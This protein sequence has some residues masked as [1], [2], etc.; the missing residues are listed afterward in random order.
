MRMPAFF[1][2]NAASWLF[3]L[4]LFAPPNSATAQETFTYVTNNGTITIT[5]YNR[6]EP[7]VTIPSTINGLPVRAIGNYAFY[8]SVSLENVTIANSVSRIGGYAFLSCPGLTNVTLGNGV[9]RIEYEAFAGCT[10]LPNIRIP[11]SVTEIGDSAFYYC[12]SL[13]AIHV[14]AGNSSYSSLDGVLFDKTQQIL[15]Q[16]PGGKTGNYVMPNSVTDFLGTAFNYSTNLSRVTISAQVTRIPFGAF[17]GC[18]GLTGVAIPDRVISIGGVAFRDCTRLT[19]VMIPDHVTHIGEAAFQACVALTNVT[20]GSSITNIGS[21]AFGDCYGL[22]KI[23]V[24]D[25]VKSIGPWAFYYCSGLTNLS[26]GR[27]LSA[28]REWA[29]AYCGGL[30]SVVM[31]E[32]LQS[33]GTNAFD[34]CAVLKGL[35]FQGNAPASEGEAFSGAYDAMMYYLPGTTGWGATFAGRPT[36]WWKLLYPVILDF[37]PG[38]GF[39][40]NRFGFI[41]SWATNAS[42]VVEACTNLANPSW[43]RLATNSLSTAG[44]S[45]FSDPKWTNAA[46]RFYR[47]RS[48]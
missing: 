7:E 4:L 16:Y 43:T 37:P 23:G 1:V 3:P 19:E 42:V 12:G 26:L 2:T 5:S 9:S 22:T 31:P 17:D 28:I 29:F 14:D 47:V 35:Y 44:W 36:A 45:Y 46:A 41:V 10:S 48:P 34:S 11:G 39:R 32:N 21:V 15:L 25:S 27:G 6:F 20:L 18:S 40:T 30:T 24:P 38:F 8:G 13:R 33:I